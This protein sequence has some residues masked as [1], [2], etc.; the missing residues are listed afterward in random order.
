[1][2]NIQF[3]SLVFIIVTSLAINMAF[4]NDVVYVLPAEPCQIKVYP[5][6]DVAA[7]SEKMS[8]GTKATLLE[9][10]GDYARVKFS[11]D[12]T[13]WVEKQNLTRAVPA[14]QEV[15]R[16]TE[17]QKQIESELAR[18]SKQVIKLSESSEKLLNALMAAEKK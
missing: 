3:K 13:V 18:L 6:P 16:L 15:L 12:M 2:Q 10:Q 11:E 17:Y 1:M 5:A 9:Q 8:C 4:A 7:L 14:E